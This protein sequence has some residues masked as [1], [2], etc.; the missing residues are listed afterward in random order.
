MA[1][2]D[3]ESKTYPRWN[4]RGGPDSTRRLR[5]CFPDSRRRDWHENLSISVDTEL[6]YMEH[7]AWWIVHQFPGSAPLDTETPANPTHSLNEV[8]TCMYHKHYTRARDRGADGRLVYPTIQTRSQA[9]AA[10]EWRM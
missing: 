3:Q 7:M 8:G 9:W 1:I 5:Y 6:V 4:F 2:D 10:Q